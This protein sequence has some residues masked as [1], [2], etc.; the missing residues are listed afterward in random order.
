MLVLSFDD[1]FP[2]FI[3]PISAKPY[4][5][6]DIVSQ[7]QEKETQSAHSIRYAMSR[8]DNLE[9]R[10]NAL[11]QQQPPL[12][13]VGYDRVPVLDPGRPQHAD[14]ASHVPAH[15]YRPPPARF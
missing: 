15:V 5:S 4:H 11:Q 8:L 7:R 14:P 13:P 9:A 3:A 12:M 2:L 10:L 6:I 1:Q